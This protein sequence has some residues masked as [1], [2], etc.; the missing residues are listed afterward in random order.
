MGKRDVLVRFVI[1]AAVWLTAA[2]VLGKEIGSRPGEILVAV[3]VLVL[4]AVAWATFTPNARLFGKVVGIGTTPQPMFAITF[5]DGPSPE[6]T[7]GVLDALRDSGARATFFVLG[8]QVRA[9]P[10]IARRIVDEGH[11]LASHG[12]DH[13]LLVFAGPRAIVHQFRAAESALSDA[14]DGRATKLFRAPHGFRNPFVSAVAG[15]EGYRMVGWHGAVFDTARPGVDAIVA[16]CRNVLRPGAILLLHD[17]DGSGQGGDRGQTVEAVP[18]IVA[19]ARERGLEPVTVSQ[20]AS[21]LRPERRTA[22]KAAA[23]TLVVAAL[24]LLVSQRYSLQVIANVFTDVDPVYVLAA[25]VANLGSVAAKSL[26]WKAA[27][28]AVP[29]D[30]EGRPLDV[31]VREVIPA[32]FIGFLLNTVLIARLGEVARVSV[33]RRKLVARDR[34]VPVTTVVGTL[35]T[36]QILSG[37]MLIGVLV[38][39]VVFTPVPQQAV[40]LLAVLSGVVLF[41]GLVA[42]GIEIA[43]RIQRRRMV[44]TAQYV[45]RWW[46][47]LGISFTSTMSGLREGQ[48]I[49]RRPRLLAWGLVM[50]TISWVMQLAGI[51]W[52]LRAYGIDEG[53]GAAGVVFLASNLV[54]LFPITPGNLGVFQ[55]ATAG[56]LSVLYPVSSDVALT[57][58]IGLQLIEAALG[59]GIGFVF[60]SLEGLSVAE[61]R[62]QVEDGPDP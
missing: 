46:H 16:R 12:D 14:V 13:S 43:G 21:E 7:P 55:G 9:H 53:L 58:S 62:R 35:V 23:F 18:H 52:A 31:S 34:P 40:R 61:L 28:D 11:E 50:A 32:I 48:A 24:V 8:R 33:L 3:A 5:D 15:Q 26:T 17:G 22:L 42:A 6:W 44:P 47:L 36:E 20:L 41:I 51:Y 29:G 56:G 38:G 59:V 2:A 49:F 27:L 19:S 37:I 10:D 39:V 60:L 4:M 1:A 54:Q 57:F 25:L 45:E 30:D